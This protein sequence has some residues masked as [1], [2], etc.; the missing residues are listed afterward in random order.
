M[1]RSNLTNYLSVSFFRKWRVNITGTQSSLKMNNLY[2]P[3]KCSQCSCHRCRSITLGDN[4]VWSFFFNNG[5]Q[6][7]NCTR[8]KLI[9]ALPWFHQRQVVLRRNAK[10]RVDLR[11]HFLVL[12]S[13]DC[14]GLKAIIGLQCLDHWSNFDR[15]WS[16]SID[17]HNFGLCHVNSLALKISRLIEA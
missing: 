7:R 10:H 3:V 9:K 5:V 1:Q 8:Y 17:G 6:A 14:N 11:K 12:P 4:E 15:L 2:T 16:S 13:R